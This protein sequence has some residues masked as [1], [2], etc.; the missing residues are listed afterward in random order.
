MRQIFVLF[1]YLGFAAS[2]MAQKETNIW[3]FGNQAG[4]DFNYNPPKAIL[5]SKMSTSEGCSVGSD[6]SGNLL[7]YTDGTTVWNKNHDTMVNGWGLFGHSSSTQSALIVNKDKSSIYY[8]FTS[9]CLPGMINSPGKGVC[10]S[11][12]DMKLDGGNG[13]VTLKN[14]LLFEFSCEKLTAVEHY[15]KRDIWIAAVKRL[16]DSIYVYKLSD[17]GLSNPIININPGAKVG[18]GQLVGGVGQMKFSSNGEYL[19]YINH[20]DTNFIELSEVHVLNFNNKTGKLAQ[21]RV[22]FGFPALSGIYGLEFSPNSRILYIGARKSFYQIP[23]SKI[24]D[25]SDVKL[26]SDYNQL[27]GNVFRI[28]AFQLASNGKIYI[29]NSNDSIVSVIN[30][31]DSI[32]AKCAFSK[33]GIKLLNRLSYLG[34]PAFVQSRIYYPV[35]LLADTACILD[36]VLL[37]IENTQVDSVHWDFGDGNKSK[38]FTKWVKH[39]YKDSGNYTVQAKLFRPNL[40]DTVIRTSIF[41]AFIKQPNFTPDTILCLGQNLLLNAQDASIK[42]YAWNT[43]SLA[44]TLLVNAA[45]TFRLTIQNQYCQWSDSIHVKYGKKPQVFIGNDTAF[46]K[47]FS[48]VLDAS[49][50]YKDY[51]WNTGQ[52]TYKVTVNQEGLYHVK[53]LDSNQCSAADTIQIDKLKKTQITMTFDSINCR[54]VSLDFNKQKGVY[55]VWNTG[56]TAS[57]IQ[58]DRKGFYVLKAANQFCSVSDSVMV[59]LLP[60]PQVNLGNDT[61]LCSRILLNSLEKGA[62]LWSEGSTSP[63]LIVNKP[64]LYWLKVS[65][66]NCSSTDSIFLMPCREMYY[67][68]PNAF[69]PNSDTHNEVFKVFGQ[70]IKEVKMEIFNRWGETIF[71]SVESD[72]AWDGQYENQTCQEGIYLY[73][74]A[75]KSYSG[76]IEYINGLVTLLR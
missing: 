65:R 7:F 13:V 57:Q 17:S 6:S 72:P 45:G 75:I 55:Y 61:M 30:Y 67:Y 32:G 47:Q 43:G 29:A 26:I 35:S 9:D 46:C 1:I 22:I 8:I 76:Q 49:N 33:N 69:S 41:V 74:I 21:P 63:Y 40:T 51:L 68:V 42:S 48:L 58:V 15:N 52:T 53:V 56:D 39:L 19:A 66:N 18:I 10:Y 62:F 23:I 73:K 20:F 37:K 36:S 64:G 59:D 38:D 16:T 50:Q 14:Q 11:V 54:Y 44:P 5:N 2:I 70:N 24:K 34:L 71:S 27:G 60:K 3:Y 12:V 25:S 4:I 28:G 31:P